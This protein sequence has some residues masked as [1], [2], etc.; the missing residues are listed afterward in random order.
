MKALKNFAKSKKSD[1]KVLLLFNSV[2]DSL[3]NNDEFD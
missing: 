3:Y 2:S 1:F